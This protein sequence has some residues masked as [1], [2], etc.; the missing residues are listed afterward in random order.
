MFVLITDFPASPTLKTQ[1]SGSETK[2]TSLGQYIFLLVKIP[3]LYPLTA[4]ISRFFVSKP[5]S[6]PQDKFKFFLDR[7]VRQW[8]W[9]DRFAYVDIEFSSFFLLGWIVDESFE[10]HSFIVLVM[11]KMNFLFWGLVFT[12]CFC[13]WVSF[14][15]WLVMIWEDFLKFRWV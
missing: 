7:K 8:S 3:S 2:P 10:V 4:I 1:T 12:W 15:L 6:L 9:S 14:V 5:F 11:I 13:F